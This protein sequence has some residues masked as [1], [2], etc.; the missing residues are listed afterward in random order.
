MATTSS[1]SATS[2]ATRGTTTFTTPSDREI[3]ATRLFAA[4][5]QL[6][7]DVHTIPEHVQRWML[8]PDGWT[9]P[10]CEID[11][12]PG[13]RWHWVWRKA[14]DGTEMEMHGEYREVQAPERLVNT[15]AWGGPYPETLNTTVFTE[16]AGGTRLTCTVLF[17]SKEAREAATAT[18][19]TGG[20]SQSYDRLDE[21]LPRLG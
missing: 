11:L 20:W 6:L 5:R 19:M 14:D 9:M 2:S 13:G 4:P 10:V 8:G 21:L 3:V 18:G 7:W 17:V 16:E 12:R 15:E 1:S